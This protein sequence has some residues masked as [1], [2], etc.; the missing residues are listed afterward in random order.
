MSRHLGREET[1]RRRP[2][3]E[4][5]YVSRGALSGCTMVAVRE[6][7]I[8]VRMLRYKMISLNPT[9]TPVCWKS[10]F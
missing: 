10:K 1:H 9:P 6:C 8:V 4:H 3:L 2:S 7:L 5:V